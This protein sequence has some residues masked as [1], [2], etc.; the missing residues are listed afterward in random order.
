MIRGLRLALF[1]LAAAFTVLFGSSIESLILDVARYLVPLDFSNFLT[2]SA[3]HAL[4]SL[5]PLL[6][7]GWMA[8]ASFSGE[9][10]R[11]RRVWT[12]VWGMAAGFLAWRAHRVWWVLRPEGYETLQPGR[13]FF[14]ENVLPCLLVGVC[15]GAAAS[16]RHSGR[17]RAVM[18]ALTA[19]CSFAW[20]YLMGKLAGR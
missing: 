9:S 19:A 15:A 18:A 7:A 11:T 14:L 12:A 4:A 16:L 10:E 1:L 5:S 8:A 3:A 6:A 2:F 17:D 20:I 13:I